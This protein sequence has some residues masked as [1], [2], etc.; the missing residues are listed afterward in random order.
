ME[1]LTDRLNY[2]NS[3]KT[4]TEMEIAL[5]KRHAEKA[6]LEVTGAERSKKLQVM[7]LNDY[8]ELFVSFIVY[9]RTCMWIG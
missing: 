5:K 7:R 4:D 2:I 9:C 6:E 8:Q 3:A 1:K